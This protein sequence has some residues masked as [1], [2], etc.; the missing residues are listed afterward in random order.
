MTFK[1][2]SLLIMALCLVKGSSA[3]FAPRIFYQ[4]RRQQY[5][6]P[7][8][9]ASVFLPPIGIGILMIAAWYATFWQYVAWSWIVTGFL[10]IISL[11][12]VV[13]LLRWPQ[14]RTKLLA[15]IA[16][17]QSQYRRQV[18][19]GLLGLGTMFGLLGIIVF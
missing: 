4:L 11:L 5:A 16:E 3:L 13:N 6:S 15:S 19:S 2:L 12:A 10:T 1:V 8:I 17:D 14:H 7:T 18:D 9:P